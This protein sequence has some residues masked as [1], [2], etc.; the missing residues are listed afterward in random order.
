[1]KFDGNR[2][3]SFMLAAAFAL[4]LAGCG[5]GGG[6]A[7]TPDPPAMPDPTPQEMC[8]GDG[9]RYN[10][11]GSCTSAADLD[12]EMAL[13]GAQEAAMAAYMAAMAAV[14][15]AV[16]PVAAGNAQMYAD[17][18]KEA[19]DAAAMAETAAMAGEYKT[20]AETA[21]A[22]AEMASGMSSLVLVNLSNKLLNGDDIENAE[23]EGSTPPKAMTNSATAGLAVA[24]AGGFGTPTH[25]TAGTTLGMLNQRATSTPPN[26]TSTTDVSAVDG[27]S[28][29]VHK[30]GGSTFTIDHGG[31]D[32]VNR[33]RTG[34]EPS[35]FH[36]KGNEAA[37]LVRTTS[38][39]T[40]SHLVV[41]TDIEASVEKNIYTGAGTEI[42]ADLEGTAVLTGDIPSDGSNF[43]VLLNLDPTD[44][45]VAVTAQIYCADPATTP[46]AIS[47]GEDGKI[48]ENTGYTYRTATGKDPGHDEDY[49]AWGMWVTASSRD[50]L[51]ADNGDAIPIDPAEAGAFVYGNE[52][53][54]VTASI[55]GKASYAGSATGLY[56][57]GGMVQ[58]FD[59]DAS[60]EVNFG[61]ATNT[62]LLATVSGSIT[63]VKA[64]GQAVDG[65]LN[66]VK[67]ELTE[68]DGAAGRFTGATDGVLG[69]AG[70]RGNWGGQLYGPNGTATTHPTGVAGTFGAASRD[71]KMG[72]I[73]AFGAH[74]Q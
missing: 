17:A 50:S 47:V 38:D 53:Y 59:A 32:A 36:I 55:T 13:S 42:T 26:Y 56:T 2:I 70:L 35:R 41:T 1:M 6:T 62:A 66:L 28:F 40:K 9:G 67:A 30:D 63:N 43:E 60:L 18:A 54:E 58:Y 12:E 3:F 31:T 25:G 57:A 8:E 29:V 49:M 39:N 15:G 21:Q 69:G 71:N 51:I 64:A 65:S 24:V 4:T 61:G 34:E 72:L 5:G 68:T 33:M 14:G 37:D 11:D 16:D 74:R 23:L 44:N 52:P 46:C 48:V 27:V 20:A 7:A 19:S 73:G 45:N 10:A 22:S